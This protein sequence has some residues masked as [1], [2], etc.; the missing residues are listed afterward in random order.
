MDLKEEILTLVAVFST[1][2]KLGKLAY[3]CAGLPL[4]KWQPSSLHVSGASCGTLS[5]D[6]FAHSE[7][8][9]LAGEGE[10]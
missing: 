1:C 8:I 10:I 7:S 2:P 5:H 6:F 3:L 9:S 4:G